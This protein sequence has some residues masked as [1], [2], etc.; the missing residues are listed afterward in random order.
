MKFRHEP[1]RISIRVSNV[2]HMSSINFLD[3]VFSFLGIQRMMVRGVQSPPE[4]IGSLGSMTQILS[5]GEY[6]IPTRWA[7]DPV[8]NG[9][10]PSLKLT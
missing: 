3:Y 1:I 2:S 8:I 10:I 9:L 7:S 4:R 6:W 5:S